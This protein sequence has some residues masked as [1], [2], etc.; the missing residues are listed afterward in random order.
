MKAKKYCK[1]RD[2]CHHTGEYK[3]A[4]NS[5]CNLKYSVPNKFL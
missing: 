2:Y 3:G 1:A 5:I 4:G